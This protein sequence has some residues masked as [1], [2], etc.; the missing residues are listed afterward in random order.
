MSYK[1]EGYNSISPYLVVDGA[2]KLV[3]LLKAVFNA[4]ETRRY[5]KPDGTIGHIE[6]KIDDSIVMLSDATE[7]FEAMPYMLHVYVPDVYATYNKAIEQGCEPVK[8]PEREGDDPDVR[9]MFKDVLGN[10][11]AVGTQT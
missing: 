2:Q 5:D 6:L 1:P 7:H 8:A 10:L 3:N 9:G 11:W 4:E